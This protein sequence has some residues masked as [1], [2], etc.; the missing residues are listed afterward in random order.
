MRIV[1]A[2]I[3]KHLPDFVASNDF[4][5]ATMAKHGLTHTPGGKP[6]TAEGI[7]SLVGIRERRYSAETENTSD[8]A[9]NAANQALI[10]AGISWQDLSVIRIGSSS[11]EKFFPNTAC[12]A[13][14]KAGGPGIEAIDVSAACTSGLA[15]MVDVKRALADEHGYQYGLAI[16]AE[17]LAT[18]MADFGDLNSNLWG[19]GAGAV[20]L[21]KAPQEEERGIICSILGS[22][23]E[24][25][26]LTESV[27]MGTRLSDLGT[28]PN[29]AFAGHDI[30]RFVLDLIPGL[31]P[32]TIEKAN[33]TLALE[34]AFSRPPLELGDIDMFAVHQANSR[35]F[36][37]PAKKL[38]IPESKFFVN[39]DRYGNMSSASVMVCLAEMVE[40]GLVGPGSL[41]MLISFGGGITYGSVLLRL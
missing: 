28:K 30:Q 1:L 12:L 24:A 8:H 35:I 4:V 38:G 22:I 27:G 36:K 23:P 29:I 2:G 16:G 7:E 9:F 32:R 14:N 13:L 10:Q 5:V 18:R 34:K 19:D 26:P 39:V 20:V 31:I 3:G 11:L 37:N 15:A 21:A 33:E 41:V 40:Q 17:V 25:A 6:I